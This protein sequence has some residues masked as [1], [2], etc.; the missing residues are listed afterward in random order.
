MA[1]K[2]PGGSTSFTAAAIEM[3][4]E[5]IT[6]VRGTNTIPHHWAVESVEDGER[7]GRIYYGSTQRM[8]KAA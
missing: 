7:N 6:P 3:E 5:R 2:Q 1:Q 4:Y 8:A